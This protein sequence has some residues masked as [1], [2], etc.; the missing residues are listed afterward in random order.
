MSKGQP[1]PQDHAQRAAEWLLARI[2]SACARV[3]VAGSL[4]RREPEVSDLDLV[5]IPRVVPLGAHS[6]L[7]L[8]NE[9]TEGVERNLL[10]ELLSHKSECTECGAWHPDDPG[11]RTCLHKDCGREC[12]HTEIGFY[13]AAPASVELVP[14]P[15]W[16]ERA[17]M[18]KWRLHLTRFDMACEIY[19]Q[20]LPTWAV[21]LMIRTGTGGRDGFAAGMVRRWAQY[22]GGGRV[23]KGIL[24]DKYGGQVPTQEEHQ[25]FAACGVPWVA[26]ERRKDARQVWERAAAQTEKERRSRGKTL[27]RM[28]LSV[29]A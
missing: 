28:R 15:K 1:K 14:D 10:H 24:R 20:S 25:V 21:N 5:I 16:K 11:F 29:P 2:A 17:D 7:S 27:R 9:G 6:Q 19:I 18:R 22:S 13:P 3:E 8:F 4:R 23:H 12:L 26:P